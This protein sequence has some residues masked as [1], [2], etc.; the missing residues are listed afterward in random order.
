M[1]HAVPAD[2]EHLRLTLMRTMGEL[3]LACLFPLILLIAAAIGASL[4]QHG[5]LFSAEQIKPKLEKI[6]PL[7]GF[8]RLFSM[9]SLAEF[10]KGIAKLAIVGAVCAMLLWPVQRDVA[11]IATLEMVQLLDLLRSLAV[12]LLV[13]VLAVMTVIAG[14]DF[15][16]QKF[17]HLKRLRMSRQELKDEFRQSEGDPLIKARLR[18]IRMERSRRRMM[19][20]VPEADVVVTNPTHF[21]VALKYDP[22]NMLAPRLTAKGTDSLAQ[23]I[24]AV[25]E[26]NEVPVV[27]NPPLARGLYATVE[28]DEEIPA[29]HYKAVAEIIGYIMKLKRRRLPAAT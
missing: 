9:R 8:K 20:A 19:A 2:F 22:E 25:A 23:R 26:A 17:E 29:E 1:P 11:N 28:L 27:E 10:V 7:Q 3:A 18:Q 12:R 15:L 24:R 13:G 16:Y 14:L 21:A 5:F 4:F 6:S